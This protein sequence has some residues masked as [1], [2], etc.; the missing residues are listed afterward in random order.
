MKYI[1]LC[2]LEYLISPNDKNNSNRGIIHD[3][4][5]R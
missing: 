3:K 2:Q 4:N 5:S 1:G